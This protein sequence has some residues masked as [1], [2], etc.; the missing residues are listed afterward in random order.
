MVN[1]QM[2][3]SGGTEPHLSETQWHLALLGWHAFLLHLP[4]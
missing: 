2:E 3:I 1:T 4:H